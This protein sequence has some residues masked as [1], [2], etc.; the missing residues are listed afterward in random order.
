MQRAQTAGPP[1][2]AADAE[3]ANDQRISQ[4]A[5]AK[6]RGVSVRT[7]HR[8][9]TDPN[10]RFPGSVEINNRRYFKRSEVVNW[11]PPQGASHDEATAD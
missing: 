4:P 5:A 6:L 10:M 7:I 3:I 11:R 9:R 8:W 2:T 1:P